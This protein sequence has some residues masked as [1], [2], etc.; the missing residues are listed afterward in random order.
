MMPA[1]LSHY[2]EALQF[3]AFLYLLNLFFIVL[4]CFKVIVFAARK[5]LRSY[6][7]VRYSLK[8]LVALEL[9]TIL[10]GFSNTLLYY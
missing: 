1:R 2:V 5:L 8:P 7:G 9:Q 4:Y 6:F 10:L 3:L